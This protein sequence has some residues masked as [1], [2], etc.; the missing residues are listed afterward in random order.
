MAQKTIRTDIKQIVSLY[1][2]VLKK[3]YRIS[4][5]Y[6][7]GSSAHGAMNDESD[8]DVA[9]VAENFIGDPVDDMVSLMKLRRGIDLRIEPR[10][11][12][13]KDFTPDNP[14]AQEIMKTG[15]RIM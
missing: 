1:A 2:E 11:I 8:I 13:S 7:Y 10:P 5:V 4:G 12:S 3:K 9:V 6:L 15:I 14:F